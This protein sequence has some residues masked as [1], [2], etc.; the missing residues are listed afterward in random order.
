M[1]KA[2]F[3]ALLPAVVLAFASM[4]YGMPVQPTAQPVKPVAQS[5]KPVTQPDK[6]VAPAAKP[7]ATAPVSS[8]AMKPGEW[9]ISG[10]VTTQPPQGGAP[11]TKAIPAQNL[12]VTPEK[13]ANFQSFVQQ[14][15]AALAQLSNCQMNDVKNTGN[16]S[17]WKFVCKSVGG[18]AVTGSVEATHTPATFSERKDVVFQDKGKDMKTI[19]NVTGKWVGA[20]CQPA[21]STVALANSL[22]QRPE[23]QSFTYDPSGRR[24][25]FL[26][27]VYVQKQ[28]LLNKKKK[29]G[30]PLEEYDLSQF[31]LLAVVISGHRYAMV[32][33]PNGK[34]YDLRIGMAA[35]VNGGHVVSIARDSVTIVESVADF[36]GVKH[37]N[38]VTLR[39]RKEEE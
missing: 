11:E 28:A 13:S 22:A 24:D 30:V 8:A 25:P 4:A 9:D 1:K 29:L 6:P 5:A 17:S 20:V 10:T 27:L 36:K 26:S 39:L 2:T 33:L 21:A 32:K 35:G 34:Y 23:D 37:N 7:A 38:A 19:F 16:G 12:C 14:P 15:N 31:Q 18:V 3:A